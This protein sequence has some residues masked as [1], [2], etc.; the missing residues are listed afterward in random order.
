MRER[1]IPVLKRKS[2]IPPKH[3]PTIAF[4]M[5]FTTNLGTYSHL[6]VLSAYAFA[7]IC[8]YTE[9][10]TMLHSLPKNAHYRLLCTNILPQVKDGCKFFLHFSPAEW[11]ALFAMPLR[12][13]GT[14]VIWIPSSASSDILFQIPRENPRI[15]N[16]SLLSQTNCS[17]SWSLLRLPI[18]DC[19]TTGFRL[20][21][22]RPQPNECWEIPNK[23]DFGNL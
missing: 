10:F 22:L 13:P 2:R 6:R 12:L 14:E 18:S 1:R 21:Y 23:G 19:A 4:V 16:S 17:F 3:A 20:F 5:N 15:P 7:F 8:I 11:S 9:S